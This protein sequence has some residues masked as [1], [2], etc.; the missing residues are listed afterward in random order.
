M[1]EEV[2]GAA[3]DAVEV[4]RRPRAVTVALATAGLL[5]VTA[6]SAAVTVAVGRPDGRTTVAARPPVA[7]QSKSASASPSA[8]PTPSATPSAAPVTPTP[9]PAPSST[10]H[11]TVDGQTHGGDIRYFLLPLPEGA[12]VYGSA[13]GNSLSSKEVAA[14]F[15]STDDIAG[16]LD[17]YGYQDDAADRHYRTL[18]GKQDVMTRLL[19]FKSRQMAK[20][21][22]RG[23]TFKSGDTFDI[24]GDDEAHGVILKPEQQAWTGELIGVG[25]VGDIE[26]EVKVLVKGTPDKALLMDAMKRQRERLA[27]GG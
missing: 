15:G 23:T 25:S 7:Q 17:S 24:D 6:A 27:T 12:E 2:D 11:G 1:S 4:R 8:S 19:R 10:V 3:A 14:E 9:T 21:F 16:V 26:Y 13:D 22:A 5:A 20:E 18:D